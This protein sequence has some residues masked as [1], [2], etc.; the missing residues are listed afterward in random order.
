MTAVPHEQLV[1]PFEDEVLVI[2]YE[3]EV[4]PVRTVAHW[5]A[6]DYTVRARAKS[7]GFEVKRTLRDH[8]WDD[9]ALHISLR[10]EAERP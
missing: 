2:L 6:L 3:R 5:I 9:G 10:A 7:L 4:E 8:A 1:L